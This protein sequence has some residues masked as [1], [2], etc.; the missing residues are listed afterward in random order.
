VNGEY[1]CCIVG[2]GAG[3]AP[4]ALRLAQAGRRVLVLEK[5][6]WWREDDFRKDELA[7]CQRPTY[8][9]DP[10]LEP[11]VV[12]EERDDG[13][14]GRRVTDQGGGFWNGNC[15]GG[16]SN[17]MSGFFHRL[18]PVDFHLR[19][20]FGPIAG[21]NV[22][23]W[24]ISYADLEP[25]YALVEREVGVSGRVVAH[26]HAEPRSTP[27]FPFPPTAEHPV[28]AL[29]DAAAEGLGMHPFPTPRAILPHPLGK[30]AGCR[31]NG[32]FCG[33]TGCSTG[34]KGSARAALLDRALAT[35]HCEI[36]PHSRVTRLLSDARGRLYAAE[37]LDATGERHRLRARLFVV[38]CQAIETARLL[39]LSRGPRF[40]HGLANGSG[41]VGRNLLFAG[42]GAGSAFL[43][44]AAF[45]TDLR[46]FGPFINRAL[47]DW[48]VI[49]DPAVG[50]RRKGGTIDLIHAHHGVIGHA[51]RQIR[52][53]R[54]LVWGKALKRRL[55]RR[56]R[57]GMLI[58]IE[59]FC[60]WLP[61]DDCRVT[62]DPRV[63]DH[64]G[65]PVARVRTGF[66]VRNLEVGWYLASQAGRLLKALGG[67]D[68]LVFASG[69]PP[70]NLQAGGCR[71]GTD[72]AVSVLDPWCRAHEVENLY[73][74]DGS[75]MPTG[76][77]VPYTWTI[78][79]NAFRVAD[80]MLR[81]GAI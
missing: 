16:S 46:S 44:Y 75:F 65:L 26:P 18:K 73:V 63:K 9:P 64:W 31:Y 76:G 38:A 4:V 11:Q 33:A 5:G 10:A 14:W 71:F 53:G 39:L 2:S 54:G 1:D 49:D 13:G 35:G 52:K 8:V 17:F 61:V 19:E 77:S 42:G 34:A 66:H 79:A 78:Y 59:A 37:Y 36:R 70:T 3:A 58:K 22:A 55:E 24:P 41:Q 56:I 32:G 29:I 72:P 48:Y 50:P 47:Q 62:L 80:H 45:E 15:V 68:V 43:P 20:T 51:L 23:D 12:E 74:T 40:P 6:P 81:T 25:W 30:R 60:D 28:S 21:A 57:D 27:D 7:C 69:A 67:R